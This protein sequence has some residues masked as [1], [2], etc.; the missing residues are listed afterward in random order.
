MKRGVPTPSTYRVVAVPQARGG[1]WL[2]APADTGTLGPALALLPDA[3]TAPAAA[4]WADALAR[5]GIIVRML[6]AT[7]DASLLRAAVALLRG[8]AGADTANVGTWASG[9]QAAALVEVLAGTGAP[10]VA[11]V[12]AQNAPMSPNSRVA[13]RELKRRRVPL[14]GLYSGATATQRAAVLRNAMGGRRG[15]TVRIYRT[16]GA[17]LLV[18]TGQGPRFAPGLPGE[19]VEWLRGR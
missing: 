10:R 2:F 3:E 8:T 19:V 14:L 7:A 9:A 16:A 1:G 13:L 6:P 17:D 18:P 12:I 5:E 15:A 4:L 11:F